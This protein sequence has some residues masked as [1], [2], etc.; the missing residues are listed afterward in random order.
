M[1]ALVLS[2]PSLAAGPALA[3]EWS[4]E[5]DGADMTYHSSWTVRPSGDYTTWASTHFRV[6]L[7]G[8]GED[9]R[10]ELATRDDG[11]W[12][13]DGGSLIRLSEIRSQIVGAVI[14]DVMIPQEQARLRFGRLLGK[15]GEGDLSLKIESLSEKRLV[16]GFGSI[17]SVCTR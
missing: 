4:C 3:G 12:S 1:A 2:P 14:D 11:R 17:R 13:M 6:D 16:A 9:E 5:G 10:L 8:D 15:P 7:D